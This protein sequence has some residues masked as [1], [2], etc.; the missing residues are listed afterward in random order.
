VEVESVEKPK[1]Y[2][3]GKVYCREKMDMITAFFWGIRGSEGYMIVRVA[4]RERDE[5]VQF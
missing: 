2:F 1:I 4:I 5:L 3:S